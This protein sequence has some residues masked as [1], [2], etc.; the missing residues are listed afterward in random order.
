MKR[1]VLAGL[2]LA[3]G[4]GAVIAQDA[5]AQR[6]DIM[7]A[8]GGATRD[9]GAM[10]KGEQP[11]DLAK[12]QRSLAIYADSAKTM[13][14]LYPAGTQTGGD[15][16]ASP[17]IWEDAAGFKAAFDKF[18]ADANAAA[19]AIKDEASF[20]ANFPNVLKNC[21]SCHEVYRVKKG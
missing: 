3:L 14:G 12:V 4:A 1:F 8:V 16:S 10:L 13:P 18:A 15:T 21:G 11:F 9:P 17:K 7:K 20:K 6:R 5:I 2:A 19:S